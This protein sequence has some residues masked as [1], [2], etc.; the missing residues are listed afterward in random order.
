[1]IQSKTSDVIHM[2]PNKV[3]VVGNGPSLR[4]FDL[5]LIEMYDWVG[6]N[7]AYRH[8]DKF[9]IYPKY[10]SCL[11]LNVGIS[12]KKEIIRLVKDS[13]LNKI[14]LF[15][16]RD[17]IIS[18]SKFLKESN[19]V[20]NYD[21]QFSSIPDRIKKQVTTGSHSLLWMH[22]LGFKQ[23]IL[24]GIDIN[25]KDLSDGSTLIGKKKDNRLKIIK[26]GLSKNYFFDNYQ[27]KGDIYTVP[28]PIPN[29]HKNSWSRIIKYIRFIDEKVSIYNGSPIS[30]MKDVD[31]LDI[32]KFLINKK[33]STKKYI[34]NGN[35]EIDNSIEFYSKPYKAAIEVNLSYLI[36]RLLPIRYAPLYI[37]ENLDYNQFK[38]WPIRKFNRDLVDNLSGIYIED[39]TYDAHSQSLVNL[40][41]SVIKVTSI[42]LSGRIKN[43][44]MANNDTVIIIRVS[45]ATSQIIISQN[46]PIQ[47]NDIIVSFSE[48]Y[49][50]NY[51]IIHMFKK[52]HQYGYDFNFLRYETRF[53]IKKIRYK[54]KLL[55]RKLG[56]NK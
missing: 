25:Y 3:F 42:D 22:L 35:K 15:L 41:F 27:K 11:D 32:K 29:L 18:S 8:W 51:E 43:E 46:T 38:K 12:H 52:I 26:N 10:Y 55:R 23:I 39:T 1:M 4:H 17:N 9:G 21:N 56:L 44:L 6:M 47:K 19:I 49:F 13:N 50:N 36:S 54:L 20:I 31:Y 37:Q 33:V 45:N 16:L 48:Y 53:F 40:G 34:S 24:L 28:N 2:I 5:S 14:K 7:A 30:K